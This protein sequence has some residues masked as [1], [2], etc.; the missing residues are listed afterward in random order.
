MNRETADRSIALM[1]DSPSP[2]ITV[3]LQ[4][5]EPLLAFDTVRYIVAEAK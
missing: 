2:H 5:G 1:L 4:G 3:E